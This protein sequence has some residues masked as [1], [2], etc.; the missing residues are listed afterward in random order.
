MSKVADLAW[1]R[2]KE[3]PETKKK[4]RKTASHKKYD[5]NIR[6]GKANGGTRKRKQAGTKRKGSG[7]KGFKKF[8]KHMQKI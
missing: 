2:P 3:K 8:L 7:K 5:T 4:K 6:F 1:A